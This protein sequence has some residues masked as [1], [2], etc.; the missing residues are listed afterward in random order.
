[1]SERIEKLKQNVYPEHL[2]ICLEKCRI[3]TETDKQTQGAPT[4]IRRAGAIANLLDNIPIFIEDGELIVGNP[5]S[6]PMGVEVDP[7]FAPFTKEQM[8]GIKGEGWGISEADEAELWSMNEYWKDKC[9]SAAQGRLLDNDRLWPYAQAGITLPPLDDKG[10]GFGGMCIS[11]IGIQAILD[12]ADYEKVLDAGLNHIIKEA[13]EELRNTRIMAPG[14]VEKKDFLQAVSIVLRAITRYANRF[15]VLAAE[16]AANESDQVRKE[17]LERIAEICQWVPAN[18]ARDFRE[19]MQSFWFVYLTIAGGTTPFGRFDQYMYPF[20]KKDIVEER[21]TEEEVLELLQCLRIKDMQINITF[22]GQ[23]QR[24]KWAG[25]AK[26]NN[27]VIGGLT[28][29]GKDATNDLTYLVLEAALRCPTPHHTIT[30]RVHDTTPESL[31][32]KALEVVRTGIGM[33]AFIS[34]KSYIEFFLSHGVTL[35]DARDYALA[36]CLDG[37]IVGKSRS[38]AVIPFVIPLV[39]DIFMHNGIEPRTGKQLGPQTGELESFQTF[40]ELM[41]A[42]KEHLTHFLG[43]GVEYSNIYLTGYAEVIPNPIISSLYFNAIKEGRDYFHRTMPFENGATIMCVGLVNVADSLAAIKK[44]VFD[45]KKVTMKELKAALDANWQGNG[46]EELRKMCLAVPKYGNDDDYVDSIVT[47]MFKFVADTIQTF[48]TIWGGKFLPSGISITSHWPGGA[49]TGATP[50]GRYAGEVLADG[51][52]SPMRGRDVNGPTAVIKSAGKIDHVPFQST[53]LNT[54]FH[55]SALK[56]TEDLSKLS[57]LIRTYFSLGGKHI[58]FNVISKETLIDAQKHPEDYRDL[59]VRVAGY[60]A[61]FISL[62]TEMQDEIIARV[63]HQL[64]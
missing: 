12:L 14:S 10:G 34:D 26:W 8:A 11:N 22:G 18:P 58:Q 44:L 55:P 28:P 50:D 31:M 52:V 23:T 25:M 36:G 62:S 49:L 60:S 37:Q 20:Y 41:M 38:L 53:L 54:K 16:M 57:N 3:F 1:M 15:A 27:M 5:A 19:A 24:E 39:L 9:S 51:A 6:K 47:E 13:E 32:L 7:L 48:D 33:P 29:D 35:E 46:Y 40:D 59:V 42:W 4:I 21:I 45:E 43:L 17:E 63:E 56:S 2:P 30:L 64:V 61:Y